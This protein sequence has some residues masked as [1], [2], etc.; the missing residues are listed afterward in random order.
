MTI[1]WRRRYAEC[2]RTDTRRRFLTTAAVVA[3]SGAALAKTND[4]GA[5]AA[6]SIDFEANGPLSPTEDLMREHGVV[7]RILLAYDECIRRID[8]DQPLPLS[9]VRDA[10]VVVQSF[11]EE[12]HERLEEEHVFPRFERSG[13]FVELVEILRRQHDAGRRLTDRIVTA[14][15]DRTVAEPLRA[16][17]R[18]YRPHA[19]REDTVLFP[20]F[21][22]LVKRSELTRLARDFEA[23]ERQL[24]GDAGFQRVLARVTSIEERL[25]IADLARAT[26]R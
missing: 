16:F 2:M 7:Q 1:D 18:M 3:A 10:A 11:V 21:R 15:D 25:G 5:A 9:V 4:R 20:A 17:V 23:R 14:L 24:F 26:P 8:A 19:A 6:A 13:R 22:A 12:Y